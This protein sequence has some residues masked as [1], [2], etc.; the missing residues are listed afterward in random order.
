M[1]FESMKPLQLVTFATVARRVAFVALAG[2]AM[3]VAS[4]QAADEVTVNKRIVRYSDLNLSNQSDA[5]ELYARLRR[6]ANSV[7][8]TFEAPSIRVVRERNE[9]RAEALSNAVAQVDNYAVTALHSQESR[10]RVAE[11]G[12]DNQPR[13]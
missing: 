9:C 11:S 4:A 8:A 2:A 12:E 13:G 10:L 5:A 1:S 3:F 6:A 7:C